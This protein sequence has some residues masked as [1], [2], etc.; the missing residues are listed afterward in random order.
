MRY[1]LSVIIPG[2][3]NSNWENIF[4][5]LEKSVGKYIKLLLNSKKSG[6][7]NNIIWGL[8]SVEE[9]EEFTQRELYN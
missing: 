7:V 5:Q 4:N 8:L 3:R 2:I 1:N 9:R 6:I